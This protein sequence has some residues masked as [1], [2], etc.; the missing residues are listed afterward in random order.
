MNDVAKVK[1]LLKILS[2]QKV[3]LNGAREAFAFTES[4][5][6]LLKLAKEMEQEAS[7]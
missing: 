1:L 2:T 6:W 7:K 4:Y 5:Q 3:E